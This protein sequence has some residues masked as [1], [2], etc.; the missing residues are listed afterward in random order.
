ML[1]HPQK[2][3]GAPKDEQQITLTLHHQQSLG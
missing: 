1:F 3:I 2:F